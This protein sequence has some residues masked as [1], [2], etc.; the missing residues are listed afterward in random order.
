MPYQTGIEAAKEEGTA[1]QLQ[2][3]SLIKSCH[4]SCKQ[5]KGVAPRS[6]TD[7]RGLKLTKPQNMPGES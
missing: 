7:T 4:E 2:A 5:E 3:L 6:S 1:M